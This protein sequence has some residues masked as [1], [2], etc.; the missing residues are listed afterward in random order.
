MATETL[1]QVLADARG[2][3]PVLR[4]RHG[5]WSPDDIS[6]FIDRIAASTEDFRRFISEDDARL[7]SGRSVSWLRARF[8][9]WMEAGNAEYRNQRRYYRVMIIPRRPDL[10]AAREAGRQGHTRV[11]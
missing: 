8:N 3:L 11:A 5:S 7:Q 2:E 6:D 9:E 4:K 10:E 1:E